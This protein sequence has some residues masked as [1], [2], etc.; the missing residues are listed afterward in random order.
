MIRASSE[1]LSG[2]TGYLIMPQ[3]YRI[4]VIYYFYCNYLQCSMLQYNNII[5]HEAV[6]FQLHRSTFPKIGVSLAKRVL[7]FE[8]ILSSDGF[9]FLELSLFSVQSMPFHK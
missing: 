8:L 1:L 5:Y 9:L 2:Q 6:K 4:M 3:L 7:L